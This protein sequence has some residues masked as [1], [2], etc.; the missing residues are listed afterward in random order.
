[1]IN[2]YG[3]TPLST[4]SY[5]GPW[6]KKESGLSWVCVPYTPIRTTHGLPFLM[7]SLFDDRR[8]L[9]LRTVGSAAHRR[10]E[11]RMSTGKY[12]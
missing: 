11:R 10:R 9:K 4:S 1:M 12:K 8:I 2:L 6:N 7:S 3:P 5:D